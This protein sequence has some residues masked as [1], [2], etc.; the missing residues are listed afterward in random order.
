[1]RLIALCLVTLLI[2]IQYPLWLGKGGWMRVRELDLQVIAAHEKNDEAQARNAKLASEVKDLKDGT[3]A[4]EERA[5]LELGMIKN[6]EI[7][8]QIATG[9]GGAASAPGTSTSPSVSPAV[10][11]PHVNPAQQAR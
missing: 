6:D 1:M 11:S 9:G 4:V 10:P 5:R 8:V 7:F 2:L 3:G